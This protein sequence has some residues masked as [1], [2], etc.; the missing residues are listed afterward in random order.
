MPEV[1]S[2]KWSPREER[3]ISEFCAK[4]FPDAPVR[5]RVRLGPYLSA[6]DPSQLSDRELRMVGSWRR[7]ADAVVVQPDRLTVIEAAIRPAVGKISQLEY[8]LRLVGS[9]PE[10][11]EFAGRPV[12]GLL[13]FAIQDP[14]LEQLAREKGFQVRYYRPP[15]VDEYLTQ[16]YSREGRPVR[17]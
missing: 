14:L 12:H 4:E 8:Y 11:L 5:L 13:L 17:S 1:R 16:I 6:L 7:W 15:W 2:A 10:L 3:L 9:T